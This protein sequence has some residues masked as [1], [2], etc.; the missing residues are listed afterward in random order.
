MDG[1]KS[2]QI[3]KVHKL[4]LCVHLKDFSVESLV[5]LLQ[6][7]KNFELWSLNFNLNLEKTLKN[8]NFFKLAKIYE[9]QQKIK[10]HIQSIK[11]IFPG[12]FKAS[13]SLKIITFT[14]N[15]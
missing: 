12:T 5:T 15:P 10:V 6:H 3:G 9:E 4:I 13:L 2:S 1:F 7:E 14:T 11:N 8:L